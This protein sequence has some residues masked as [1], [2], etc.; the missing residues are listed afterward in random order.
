MDRVIREVS[1][2]EDPVAV[3][4]RRIE[5]MM[6]RRVK[7]LT[8]KEFRVALE[9]RLEPC[10]CPRDL[11]RLVIR[12][13]KRLGWTQEQLAK[14]AGPSARTVYLVENSLESRITFA[15]ALRLAELLG[16]QFRVWFDGGVGLV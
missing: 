4:V 15:G 5:D 1:E 6:T 9:E 10:D 14:K 2:G 3:G 12:E 7:G 16:L 13:W 11:A 8:E